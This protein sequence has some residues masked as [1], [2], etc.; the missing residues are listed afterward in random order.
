MGYRRLLMDPRNALGLFGVV[1][2]AEIV[3]CYLPYP[4]S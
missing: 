2:V 3:G 1:V 4:P